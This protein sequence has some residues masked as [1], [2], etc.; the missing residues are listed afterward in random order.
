MEF[1]LVKVAE[2]TRISWMVCPVCGGIME[3]FS[4]SLCYN[5][6]ALITRIGKVFLNGYAI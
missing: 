6:P 4:P 5:C 2:F 1:Y 3:M